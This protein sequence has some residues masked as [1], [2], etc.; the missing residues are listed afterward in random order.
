MTRKNIS[1]HRGEDID[2][3]FT[4]TDHDGDT[5]DLTGN[6]TVKLTVKPRLAD[7]DTTPVIEK[8]TTNGD[9][10]GN[11]TFD[12]TKDDLDIPARSYYYEVTTEFTGT[13]EENTAEPYGSL[14]VKKRT[15]T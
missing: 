7:D 10:S 6:V 1:V 3:D 4:I 11:V 12:L 2:L 8:L 14:N 15:S 13:S 5:I 9:A